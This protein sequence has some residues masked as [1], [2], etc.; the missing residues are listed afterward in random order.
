MNYRQITNEA[1]RY[2]GFKKH[3]HEK[4][5]DKTL[6]ILTAS[7]QTIE[8][9]NSFKSLHKPFDITVSE[10]SVK[11]ADSQIDFASISLSK[12]LNSSTK[13]VFFAATL[14]VSVDRHSSKL[15]RESMEKALIFDAVASAYLEYKS[16]E[17]QSSI[18]KDADKMISISRFSPG[19]GDLSM[20]S[21][22][23]IV[24]LLNAQKY[25]GLTLTPSG[26]LLPRKS[27]VALFP[28]GD[29]CDTFPIDCSLCSL[30]SDC[31]SDLCSKILP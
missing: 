24:N 14:G 6:Q 10:K 13:A 16:D 29:N 19:Y 9:F 2:L 31:S 1:L 8:S 23:I 4:P 27:I 12:F 28:F 11:I 25:I 3:L 15:A 26:T 5:D 17:A 20:N 21:N 22:E 18:L 30:S 7:L